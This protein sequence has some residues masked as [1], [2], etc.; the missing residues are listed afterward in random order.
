MKLLT[1]QGFYVEN[2]RGGMLAWVRAGL[3]VRTGSGNSAALRTRPA[4]RRE[5]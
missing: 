4:K 1:K 5:R 2:L 3:P